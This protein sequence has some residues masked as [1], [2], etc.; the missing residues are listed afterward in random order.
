[1]S[2]TSPALG[3]SPL[4]SSTAVNGCSPSSVPFPIQGVDSSI[5]TCIVYSTNTTDLAVRSCCQ[6]NP[7]NTTA[8]CEVCVL[9]QTYLNGRGPNDDG[10]VINDFSN[11]LGSWAQSHNASRPVAILCHLPSLM[12][13]GASSSPKRLAMGWM[14]V[15]VVLASLWPALPT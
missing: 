5:D 6:S 13:S 1:M 4:P 9:P 11:C 8:S 12:K 3:A 15:A 14:V 10:L 2:S 7:V